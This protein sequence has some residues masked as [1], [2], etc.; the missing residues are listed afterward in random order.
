VDPRIDQFAERLGAGW[1]MTGSGSAFFC[2]C[3]DRAAAQ[4]ATQKL[5]CWTAVSQAVGGW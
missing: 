3:S 4:R 1:Q 5:D 2:V